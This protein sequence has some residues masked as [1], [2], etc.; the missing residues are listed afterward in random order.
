M[1]NKGKLKGIMAEAGITQADLAKRINM[2]PNTL[3]NKLNGKRDFMVDEVSRIC[4]AL[5]I[6]DNTTK[7]QIFLL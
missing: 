7:I 1:I 2:S 5:N 4:E 3:S 6:S